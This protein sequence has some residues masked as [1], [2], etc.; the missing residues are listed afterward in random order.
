M[1]F[2]L[3][4]R[5]CVSTSTWVQPRPGAPRPWSSVPVTFDFLISIVQACLHTRS[6]RVIGLNEAGLVYDRVDHAVPSSKGKSG[7]DTREPLTTPYTTTVSGAPDSPVLSGQSPRR[8]VY[9]LCVRLRESPIPVTRSFEEK[10]PWKA[11]LQA[12]SLQLVLSAFECLGWRA[13]AGG[14]ST[15]FGR[16]RGRGDRLPPVLFMKPGTQGIGLSVRAVSCYPLSCNINLFFPRHTMS[17]VRR[18]KRTTAGPYTCSSMCSK[19]LLIVSAMPHPKWRALCSNAGHSSW[20][21]PS[22]CKCSFPQACQEN[23]FRWQRACF[24]ANGL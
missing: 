4:C 7:W 15:S 6:A 1:L 12:S 2:L 17:D 22:P 5:L 18:G 9:C 10:T 11:C 3:S 23:Y 24:R 20:H 8:E 14:T 16:E 13:D 19:T 21:S